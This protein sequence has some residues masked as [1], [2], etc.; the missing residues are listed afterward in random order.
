MRQATSMAAVIALFL[1]GVLIGAFGMHL[2]EAHRMPWTPHGHGAGPR[3]DEHDPPHIL[4][5]IMDELQLS[6]DQRDRI[7]D[8]LR[9]GRQRAAEMRRE[10]RPRVEEEMARTHEQILEV[11]TPSQR[12]HLE[13]LRPHL[14]RRRLRSRP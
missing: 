8:I 13:E 4:Q 6:P 10:V 3:A 5:G 9:Q 11:L 14:H 12:R 7:H 1:M 2:V